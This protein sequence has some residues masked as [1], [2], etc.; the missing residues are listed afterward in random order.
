MLMVRDF[1]VAIIL[2]LFTAISAQAGSWNGLADRLS[3][4][5]YERGRILT[6]LD[7]AA[8][9][10]DSG[11]M[12]AKIK[13]LYV[14]RY[15]SEATARV[16]RKLSALGYGP[17]PA[18]G[19]FGKKTRAALAKFQKA[20]GLPVDGNL[21]PE[22]A[23]IV[24]ESKTRAP[25]GL[26]APELPKGR[27]LYQS[28]LTD[29]RLEEARSFYREN[30]ALLQSLEKEYG[31]PREM[32]V[33]V[34]T[35]ETRLGQNLGQEMAFLTLASMAACRDYDSISEQFSDENV[36]AARRRWIE[37]TIE[38]K[39][40]WAYKEFKAL[41]EYSERAGLH[42][43]TLPGSIY[44]AIG[45]SQFM[46]TNALAFGVDGDGDGV[47]NLFR[48]P[49]ALF[50]MANFM[51]HHAGN[52]IKANRSRQRKAL[53]CYNPSRIYVNT[54]MAVADHLRGISAKN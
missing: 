23:G 54:V 19:R 10:P 36:T 29:E 31:V 49:D 32:A 9:G 4:D 39:S 17:G 34:L 44:G 5:G 21:T 20:S 48:T 28:V 46:P 52:K 8:Q 30:L 2:V 27:V 3:V 43:L 18:D 51:R 25:R 11:Y 38:K 7:M 41:I 35:V 26:A 50:S 45:I 13:S 53:Y 14:R 37:R 16:Q 1:P 40:E 42:P 47:V 33:G 12:A 22:L 24:L 15:G 6:L